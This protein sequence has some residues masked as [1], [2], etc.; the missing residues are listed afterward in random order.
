LIVQS[1]K[2]FFSR[3]GATTQRK[4]GSDGYYLAVEIACMCWAITGFG[5]MWSRAG[6]QRR[7]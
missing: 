7:L 4:S 2:D 3:N 6:R 1:G 5:N